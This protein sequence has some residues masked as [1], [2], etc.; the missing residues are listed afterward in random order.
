[1]NRALPQS[2]SDSVLLR[3]FVGEGKLMQ[4]ATVAPHGQP[5]VSHCWYAADDQLNLIF[6]SAR[7]EVHSQEL[8][9]D[10]R[11]AGSIAVSS[12]DAL[13]QRVRRVTFQGTAEAVRTPDL[14]SAYSIYSA[15]WPQVLDMAPLVSFKGKKPENRLY[16]IVPEKYVLCDE[17]TYL[18]EPRREPTEW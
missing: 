17:I 15:R 8:I 3:Q 11:V 12:L 2:R 18:T 16:V 9:F 5:R 6:A 14:Q 7:S 4:F 1:M 13:G 10:E